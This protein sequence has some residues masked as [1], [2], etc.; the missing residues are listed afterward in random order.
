MS[1]SGIDA[2]SAVTGGRFRFPPL[3]SDAL[4][5]I[6]A[7]GFGIEDFREGEFALDVKSL[8]VYQSQR[9]FQHMNPS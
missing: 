7:V 9:L 3:D 2:A 6:K 4:T 5:A 8:H 1:A